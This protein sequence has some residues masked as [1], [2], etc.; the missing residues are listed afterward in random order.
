MKEDDSVDMQL[1]F[2]EGN[3]W[4]LAEAL[5]LG[6]RRGDFPG[7]W[8]RLRAKWYLWRVRRQIRDIEGLSIEERQTRAQERA[9][10]AANIAIGVS[11]VSLVIS[12]LAYIKGS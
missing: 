2:H 6:L 11:L 7:A 8:Q 1:G 3:P 5:D 10:L 4:G 12:V 9:A